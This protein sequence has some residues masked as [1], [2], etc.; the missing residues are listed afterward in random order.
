MFGT[1]PGLGSVSYVVKTNTPFKEL[2]GYY[3][4]QGSMTVTA[5][6]NT[7]LRLN[8]LSATSVQIQIDKNGD[9]VYEEATTTTWNELA[10]RL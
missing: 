8:V 9:G 4:Y 10:S 3:P 1:F 2:E 7:S 6:D 5:T